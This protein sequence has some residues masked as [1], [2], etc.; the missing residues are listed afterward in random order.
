MPIYDYKCVLCGAVEEIQCSL[1]ES[2]ALY[3]CGYKQMIKI[4]SKPSGIHFKGSGFYE[5]DYKGKA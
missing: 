1:T 5:T 4:P 2:V 3:H